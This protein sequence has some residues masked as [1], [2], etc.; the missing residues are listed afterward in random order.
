MNPKS[1]KNIIRDYG[2]HPTSKR[3]F[4][5]LGGSIV[6]H[7]YV[8]LLKNQLGFG[9][10]A[11][12]LLGAKG[13]AHFMFN[14]QCV[15]QK[16]EKLLSTRFDKLN[17]IIFEPAMKIYQD[18]LAL[19]QE[20]ESNLSQNPVKVL[21]NIVHFYPQYFLGLGLYNCLW[22]YLGNQPQRGRFKG[23]LVKKLA[24]ER[25]LVATLYSKIEALIR[26]CTDAIGE[27]DKIDGDLIRYFS[28]R[29]IKSY[30]QKPKYFLK[31]LTFLQKRRRGFFYLAT[32]KNRE[33]LLTQKRD[34]Q[35]ICNTYY[36]FDFDPQTK[37]IQGVSAYPGIVRGIVYNFDQ[38]S[39]KPEPREKY[40]LVTAMTDPQNVSLAHKALAIVTDE[41]GILNHAAIVARELK[42]P[43]IIDTKIAT[44]VLK[45]GDEVEVDANHGRIKITK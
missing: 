10:R 41:G 4:S 3:D 23:Q 1:L 39:Q 17:K 26:A 38:S 19:H 37:E 7:A 27:Q 35:E 25:T 5:L 32:E 31:M 18:S 24:K 6:I 45:D 36:A 20:A 11:A 28:E 22:R 2:L 44:K 42:I 43:C 40:I 29:E 30:F 33:F 15:V 21:K 9:Y 14:D 8:E 12:G 34:L 16:T 13:K